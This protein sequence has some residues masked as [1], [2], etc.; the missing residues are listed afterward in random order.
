MKM[1]KWIT[2]FVLNLIEKVDSS[3]GMDEEGRKLRRTRL[4]KFKKKSK[5]LIIAAQLISIWYLLIITGSYLTSDTGAYFND[6]ERIEFPLQAGVWEEDEEEPPEYPEDDGIWGNSSL[7]ED[8]QGGSCAEGIFASFKNT[9]DSV[10]HELTK[11]EVYWIISGNAKGGEVVETGTFP[12]PNSGETYTIHYKPKKN[13][14]YKFKAYHETGHA[15]GNNGNDKGPWSNDIK[16]TNCETVTDDNENITTDPV[17]VSD[18]TE[19]NTTDDNENTTTDPTEGNDNTENNTTDE[20]ESGT[21][22]YDNQENDVEEDKIPPS[23]VTKFIGKLIKPSENSNKNSWKI[24]LNWK[25]PTEEDFSK[26][27]IFHVVTPSEV[28]A[29]KEGSINSFS[30][31]VKNLKG[32]Q[33]YIFKI[34]TVDDANNESKGTEVSIQLD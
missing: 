4:K 12:I 9:G 10:N 19:N 5:G 11:Y 8:N 13:G 16:V 31:D 28:I 22:D 27:R 34:T 29:I 15:N 26:V 21:P 25:N 30:F 23:E 14:V 1:K 17:E 3:S 20:I 6:I 24:E 2:N 32:A 7:K 18:N 33:P